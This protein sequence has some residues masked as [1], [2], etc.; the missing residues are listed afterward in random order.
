MNRR[1]FQFRLAAI[2]AAAASLPVAECARAADGNAPRFLQT[3]VDDAVRRVLQ[4]HALPGMAI[5]VVVGGRQF[6]FNYGVTAPEGAQP[7]TADTIFEIGSLSKTFTATLASYARETGALSFSDPA[8]AHWSALAGSTFDRI[9]LLELGTYSAGGLPLQFPDSVTDEAGMLAYFRDWHPAFEPGTQRV[10]SNPSMGLFGHLAA[11]SLGAPF[12]E[13][14]E[15]KLFPMLGLAGT[16]IQVPQ[17]RMR[18]YAWG[19]SKDNRPIRVTPG[20]FDAPAYGV[21]TS[22]RDMLRFVQSNMNGGQLPEALRR[23]VTGTHTGYFQ[24]GDMTQGLGWEMYAYPTP[25][26]RLLAGNSDQMALTAHK[27]TRL[28]PPRAPRA[29]VLIDKTGSTNGFGAYAAFVPARQLGVVLLANR[30]Y[31]NRDRVTAAYRILHA[32]ES[33]PQGLAIAE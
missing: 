23:A 25:L 11:A 19:C 27:E 6:F 33:R 21:K 31:P 1:D 12:P 13:L 10:Y 4:K 9:T 28:D 2:G 5:A 7:V 18:D 26:D 8:S 17:A 3:A 24:V 30:N 32:L 15:K 22:A 20:V 16:Y 14:M 29:D